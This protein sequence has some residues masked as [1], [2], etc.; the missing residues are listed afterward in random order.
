MIR[1]LVEYYDDGKWIFGG[2]VYGT[3]EKE[4][5]GTALEVGRSLWRRG[6]AGVRV[7]LITPKIVLERMR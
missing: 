7:T 1:G 3:T 2:N 6:V 4:T 5:E